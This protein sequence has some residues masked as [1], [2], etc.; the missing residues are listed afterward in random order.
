MQEAGPET[1]LGD[2]DDVGF[3]SAGRTTRFFR[4]GDAYFVNAEGPGGKPHD[5]EVLY[6][7]GAEPLQ[8]Y[9]VA[10][11]GGRLQCLDIAWDCVGRRW[12]D[13]NPDGRVLHDDPY[14]WSGRFQTWNL[15]CADCHST[16]FRKNYDPRTDSYES[17]W[18]EL[19]VGCEACHGPGSG[20]VKL[21]RTWG[22]TG[23]AADSASGFE[24]LLRRDDSAAVLNSCAPCHS[25]RTPLTDGHRPGADFA[26]DYRLALLT[27][28]LYHADG[29]M[30]A[31]VYVHGSF[32]QSKMHQRGVNCSDC[33]DPHGLELWLPGDGVCLQCHSLEAPLERFP[34]LA[35][36]LYA[37][38]SHHHHAQ[39]SE[40]ARCVSCHMPTQTYMVIDARRDHSLRI[41]RPDLTLALDTPNACDTCHDDRSAA[42][43]AE[44]I[45]GWTGQEPTPHYGTALGA[46]DDSGLATL[47]ALLALPFEREVPALVRASA[48]ERLP[49]GSPLACQAAM[50]LLAGEEPDPLLRAA[51]L[52]A[53]EGAPTEFLVALVPAHLSDPS[54]LVRIE[55]AHVL[56][57]AAEGR[58]GE[59]DA[60]RFALAL[61]EFEEAQRV[62]ADSPFAHLN[63][64]VVAERR[65]RSDEAVAHYRRALALDAAFLPAVFN[66]ATLLEGTHR[67]PAA[68]ALLR[69]AI[70]RF[71]EEGQLRYSLG[72]LL[73]GAGRIADS[74]ETLSAAARLLPEEAR[75]H[76][77]LG[78]AL[79]QSD[80]RPGA[81]A[82]FL[83][84]LQIKPAEPD[85][86]YALCTFYLEGDELQ[87][88]HDW[89]ERL[90]EA[91]PGRPGPRELLAEIERRMRD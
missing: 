84:A 33:H 23:R 79:S 66:L 52:G 74:A 34:T 22:E 87:R 63:L 77:N 38:P 69:G 75:V 26:D 15:Q 70:E 30:R 41:P 54:R 8:Q 37:D 45:E 48:L 46:T 86:V 36:K 62:N 59:E 6:T 44:A 7:F 18:Q 85:F 4:V 51:A 81:E 14:H 61:A 35:P 91:V 88:A 73:A 42:W 47:E 1:V 25:R 19:D 72:L 76:Y 80:Q 9:L 2:F 60:R 5:Y 64:G 31:E 32:L 83:R 53:L 43:A 10:F 65:G 82:A 3:E 16:Y 58:L 71:P 78:L 20:H 55:A 13:L 90:I 67:S 40:G 21:A 89:T 39:E 50:A 27:P 57:G 11:P 56:A 29:Q 12:F 28:D 24:V 17:T 49:A 68:E